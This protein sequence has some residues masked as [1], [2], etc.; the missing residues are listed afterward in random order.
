LALHTPGE[1][2]DQFTITLTDSGQARTNIVVTVPVSPTQVP[3]VLEVES[4]A[5]AVG[6]PTDAVLVDDRLYIVSEDGYVRVFD[7]EGTVGTPIAVDWSSSTIAAAPDGSRL[8][9]DSPWAGTVSVIDTTTDSVVA[10]IWLPPTTYENGISH[11]MVVSP[12]GTRLYAA[13]LDGTVS[14]ID[15]A[16]NEV[17]ASQPLGYFTDI[18]ISEDGRYLYGTSGTTVIT[19]PATVSVIDTESMTPIVTT[20]LGP[21][22]DHTRTS[23]EYA[24]TTHSAAVNGDGTQLYVT[25]HVT[26]VERAYGPGGSIIFSNGQPWR[27]TGGYGVVTVIDIDPASTTY[28]R[29]ITTVRLTGHAQD[30]A[31]SADGSRAFVTLGDGRTVAVIDTATHTVVGTFVT[32]EDGSAT[33]YGPLR[34]VLLS[35]DTLYVTD[36]ADGAVYAVTGAPGG[37]PAAVLT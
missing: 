36:Y 25:Y 17:V 33:P 29:E 2:A 8:Y 23:G 21:V 20:T 10:T 16:T 13:G 15:T 9:I 24:D 12:D 35:G 5:I 26:T 30:L 19:D 34:N 22:W 31:L 1:D 14:V 27:I 7:A 11:Q 37:A 32:D 4:T 3:D 6:Y 18:D 28:G